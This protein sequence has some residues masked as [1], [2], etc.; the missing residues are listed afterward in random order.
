MGVPNLNDGS[1][2]RADFDG[3]NRT[4]IVAKGGTFTP[5]QIQL[6]KKTRKCTGAT[7]RAC[8]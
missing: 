1:L 8:G 7:A 3:R 5:K 2:E 6:E 4:T